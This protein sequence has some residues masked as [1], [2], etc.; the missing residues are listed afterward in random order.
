MVYLNKIHKSFTNMKS[1]NTET[2]L[3]MSE[4]STGSV[5][6]F[7]PPRP[8]VLGN[9]FGSGVI[10]MPTRKHKWTL[11]GNRTLWKCSFESDTNVREYM[12]RKNQLWI[13]RGGR[14]MTSKD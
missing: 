1:T 2:K 4:L 5:M 3:E 13:E 7:K 8:E 14:Q 6:V 9:T 11:E 12:E 10:D